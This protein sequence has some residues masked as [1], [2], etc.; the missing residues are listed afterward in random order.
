M[1]V[2][3]RTLLIQF[4]YKYRPPPF[5]ITLSL[6]KRRLGMQGLELY[7]LPRMQSIYNFNAGPAILP[8]PVLERVQQELLELP[9]VGMSVLEISHRSKV[10]EDIIDRTEAG[11][12][13]LLNLPANYRVL[14]LQGGAS[15]QFSMVPLNLLGDGGSADYILTGRATPTRSSKVKRRLMTTAPLS[16]DSGAV[17]L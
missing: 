7:N 8:R 14:F 5:W 2:K 9:G 11:L 3:T 15:L 6:S 17:D 16:C 13:E 1:Q 12:R 10:F 4:V